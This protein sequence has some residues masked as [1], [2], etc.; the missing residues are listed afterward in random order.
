VAMEQ[1][2]RPIHDHPTTHQA[3]VNAIDHYSHLWATWI[4]ISGIIDGLIA[5]MMRRMS[6]SILHE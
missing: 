2:S 4:M 3:I 1:Q 5:D 6:L